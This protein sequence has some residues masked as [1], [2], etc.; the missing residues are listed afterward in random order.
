MFSERNYDLIFHNLNRLNLEYEVVKVVPFI[1]E[2]ENLQT[3]RKD[4]WCFGS[5]TL[6]HIAYKYGFNPGSMFNDN[7]DLEIYAP[8]YGSNMLN[9]DGLVMD[10]TDPLPEDEKWTM[11]FAR[12]T[13]D[14]KVFSG[15][16]FMRHSWNE[17]VA[18]VIEN[19]SSNIITDK[20]KVFICPLKIIYQEIRCWVVNGKVITMSQYKLGNRITYQNLDHDEEAFKFAQNMADIYQPARAFVIDICRTEIGFKIVEINCINCAGFYDMNFQKLLVALEEEF[21]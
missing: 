3:E 5:I 4:V 14:T 17:Y 19:N 13:R 18:H 2:I 16:V 7:H 8:K 1:R 15:Q 21:N 12:P 20:T 9:Y 11:F 10:F 6:A